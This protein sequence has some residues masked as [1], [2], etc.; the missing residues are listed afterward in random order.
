MTSPVWNRKSLATQ[1]PSVAGGRSA[2][3]AENNDNAQTR[4]AAARRRAGDRFMALRIGGAATAPRAE[5]KEARRFFASGVCR[6][7]CGASR[8]AGRPPRQVHELAVLGNLRQ[9][10]LAQTGIEDPVGLGDQPRAGV[11]QQLTG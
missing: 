7:G 4:V 6:A 2:A 1:S 10:A 11:G 5:D 8:R 3:S 9:E